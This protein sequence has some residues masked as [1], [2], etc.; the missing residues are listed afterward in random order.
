MLHHKFYVRKMKEE[1]TDQLVCLLCQ[2]LVSLNFVEDEEDRFLVHMKAQHDAY[3]NLE[4]LKAACKMDK[5]E[6][7]AVMDVMRVKDQQSALAIAS[8]NNTQRKA[9]TFIS[10][11]DIKNPPGN[12]SKAKLVK[13]KIFTCSIVGCDK[14]FHERFLDLTNHK[15]RD[16][17]LSKKEAQIIS[18]KHVRYEQVEMSETNPTVKVTLT[19]MKNEPEETLR[20]TPAKINLSRRVKTEP[21]DD[22]QS[23]NIVEKISDIM[24][25]NK[26]KITADVPFLNRIIKTERS[27]CSPFKNLN[28]KVLSQVQTRKTSKRTTPCQEKPETNKSEKGTF[29]VRLMLLK[30]K[31]LIKPEPTDLIHDKTEEFFY[32]DYCDFN[33]TEEIEYQRHIKEQKCIPS[34]DDNTMINVA[35]FHGIPENAQGSETSNKETYV[36]KLMDKLKDMDDSDDEDD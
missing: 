1:R 2:G 26:S 33:S 3:F 32:C 23:D 29:D 34:E 36:A 13:K 8:Q 4:F 14:E 15:I 10:K 35:D 17:H 18:M 16:H 5:D 20:R 24:K 22:D 31:T 7:T 6:M 25:T 28:D 27:S 11:K 21:K 12:S 30:E 9:D 19:K